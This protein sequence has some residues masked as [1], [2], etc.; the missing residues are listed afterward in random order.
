[1]AMTLHLDIVS[2]EEEIY[3]GRA[4]VVIVTGSMGELGIYPGHTPL[5]TSLKPGTVR[6]LLQHGKE[7][8]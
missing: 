4:E 6:A 5:L 3:S 8:G 7:E 1:M 2:V